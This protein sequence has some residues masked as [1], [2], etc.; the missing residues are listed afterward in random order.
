[1]KKLLLATT[2]EGKISEYKE[3]FKNFGIPLELVTLKDLNITQDIE[4]EGSTFEENAVIKAK[5]YYGL[6]SLP[7]LSDDAGLEID[8][9]NGEPGV[10]S[11]R[12]PGYRATDEEL[13]N[14]AI[15][16]MKGVQKEKRGAQLRAVVGLAFPKEEKIYT[17][18]GILRGYI[19]EKPFQK[20]LAGYPFRSIFMPAGGG[21]YLSELN[22]V[23]HRKQAIEKALPLIKKYLL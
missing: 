4:E 16:K 8:Y 7:T 17:F 2:N 22:I 21:R 15:E 13:M 19:T 9:L 3:I 6:S 14:L 20:T 11:R 1:M 18:E 10:H 12:W 23:A 5:F